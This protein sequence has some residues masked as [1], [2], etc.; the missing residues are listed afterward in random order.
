MR[1]V[2]VSTSASTAAAGGVVVP[3]NIHSD[4]NLHVGVAAVSGTPTINIQFTFQ[5]P[6]EADANPSTFAWYPVAALTSVS[7]TLAALVT[8]PVHAIRVM[9]PDAGKARVFVLQAEN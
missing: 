2:T 3:T 4:G 9:Q 7:T 8:V 5:N 6:L 1:L